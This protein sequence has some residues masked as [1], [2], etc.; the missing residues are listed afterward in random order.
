[1][2]THVFLDTETTGIEEKDRL[3]QLCYKINDTLVNE[4]Y[5]PGMHIP[6]EASMVHHITNKMVLDKPTF[7]DSSEYTQLQD[8]FSD[9]KAIFIAHNAKFDLKML[10]KEGIV[11][12]QHICT[13]KVVRAL[14]PEG[15][16]SRYSLQYLRY[17]LDMEIEATAHDAMGDVLVLEQLFNRFL[18]KLEKELGTYEQAIKYMLD[19]STKPSLIISF[20]FGKYANQKVTDVAEKDP[21]YLEWLL[22]QKLQNE[23]DDED[24]IYTLKTALHK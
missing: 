17:F 23:S 8:L 22:N 15:K 9:E 24:W 14:D 16:L 2:Y 12:K 5:N 10:A 13:Y 1:M 19:V 20:N 11:P 21:G 7:K 4:L 6:A 3:C 18:T